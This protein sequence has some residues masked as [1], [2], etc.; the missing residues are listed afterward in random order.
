MD[1]NTSAGRTKGYATSLKL[2]QNFKPVGDKI[3]LVAVEKIVPIK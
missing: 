3:L 1:S 2:R